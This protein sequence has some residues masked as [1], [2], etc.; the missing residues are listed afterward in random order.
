MLGVEALSCVVYVK[1][2]YSDW[3]KAIPVL[4][5]IIVGREVSA[6]LKYKNCKRILSFDEPCEDSI[7]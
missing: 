3:L 6:Q 2:L 4:S 5:F 7:A 1:Y